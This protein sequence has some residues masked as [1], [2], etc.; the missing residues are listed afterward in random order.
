VIAEG[1]TS[2]GKAVLARQRDPSLGRRRGE[3]ARYLK[4][5]PVAAIDM[6]ATLVIVRA[7]A[8]ETTISQRLI[9]T[10]H[11]DRHSRCDGAEPNSDTYK[12]GANMGF[13]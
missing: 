9:R 12:T 8:A 3:A 6:M 13:A 5:C 10:E 7:I 2:V 1:A 11:D 4:A